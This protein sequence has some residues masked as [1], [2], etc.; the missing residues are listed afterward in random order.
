MPHNSESPV[1]LLVVARDSPL[2]GAFADAPFQVYPVT[3]GTLATLE[4]PSLVPDAIVIESVLPDMPGIEACRRLRSSPRIG[5]KVPIVVSISEQPTPAQ[6]VEGLREGVWDFIPRSPG[7]RELRYKLEAYLQV[8][9]VF[10]EALT[11]ACDPRF[12]SRSALAQR[13]RELGALMARTKGALAC[14]ALKVDAA[15]ANGHTSRIV[16]ATARV[17]DMIV[18]FSHEEYAVLAPLTDEAG[19]RRLAQRLSTALQKP[20]IKDAP[21]ARHLAFGYDVTRN[22]GYLAMD[23]EALVLHAEAAI[24]Q[25]RPEPDMPWLG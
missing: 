5:R 14:V 25:G 18:A 10:E 19:A 24:H 1:V 15:S 22:V 8:R 21:P 20:A 9:Q 3:S 6:R 11:E 2:P 23:P 17:S 4:A 12:L 13:A 16:S 7:H